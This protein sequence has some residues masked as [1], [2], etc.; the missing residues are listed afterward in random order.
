MNWPYI[1]SARLKSDLDLSSG[2][3][4]WIRFEM[5]S[6]FLMALISLNSFRNK[7][8]ECK[9]G[10]IVKNS[11]AD[12]LLSEFRLDSVWHIS[13][14]AV[15]RLRLLYSSN[16]SYASAS[17][18]LTGRGSYINI[19]FYLIWLKI[20]NLFFALHFLW[21]KVWLKNFLTEQVLSSSRDFLNTFIGRSAKFGKA[22]IMASATSL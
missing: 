1:S 3:F 2:N 8:W 11:G 6:V 13:L 7:S 14:Q 12:K 20:R 16:L 5:A 9:K 15:V 18:R 19:Y 4:L 10:H 22:S 17:G 21:R